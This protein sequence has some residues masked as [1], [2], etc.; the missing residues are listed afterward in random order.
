VE[1]AAV[2]VGLVEGRDPLLFFD[3][4]NLYS[5]DIVYRKRNARTL[6]D[7]IARIEDA[8]NETHDQD[9]FVSSSWLSAVA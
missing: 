9:V 3:G 7:T 2:R 6:G 8:V 4:L 5:P 1:R